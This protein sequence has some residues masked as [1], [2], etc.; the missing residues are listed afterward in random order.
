VAVVA[1]SVTPEL[2]LVVANRM[3]IPFGRR[4]ADRAF[5]RMAH[6]LGGDPRDTEPIAVIGLLEDLPLLL[7][8]GTGDRTV[9]PQ[10]VQR[11]LAAAP[12]GG[13]Q[14]LIEGAGHGE[15]H[16]VDPDAYEAA[17]NTLIRA[18]FSAGRP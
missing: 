10:D 15:G 18:A 14:L 8:H 2:A 13:R 9:R 5:G 7:V 17:V 12:A 3:R 11:L 6:R 4:I 16:A 1:D